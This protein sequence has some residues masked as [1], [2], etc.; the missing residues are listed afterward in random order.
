MI[1]N[2]ILDTL[3]FLCLAAGLLICMLAYFDV[4]TIS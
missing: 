4:L 2:L 3:G 1:R